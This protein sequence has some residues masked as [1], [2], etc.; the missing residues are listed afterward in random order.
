MGQN[1]LSDDVLAAYLSSLNMNNLHDICFYFMHDMLLLGHSITHLVPPTLEE[2]IE[3]HGNLLYW[4]KTWTLS[5]CCPL[6]R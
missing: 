5:P 3:D 1:D 2:E 6:D 4:D